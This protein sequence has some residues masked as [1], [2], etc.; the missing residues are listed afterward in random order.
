MP[1]VLNDK[2]PKKLTKKYSKLSQFYQV[3]LQGFKGLRQEKNEH[4]L[5]L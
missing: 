3:T 2:S 1:G 4:E 5:R